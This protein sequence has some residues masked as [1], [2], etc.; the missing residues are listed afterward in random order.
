MTK[1]EYILHLTNLIVNKVKFLS[2]NLNENKIDYELLNAVGVDV[3]YPIFIFN[4]PLNKFF[5]RAFLLAKKQVDFNLILFKNPIVSLKK[6]KKLNKTFIFLENEIGSNL[7][8]T[9]DALNINY[10]VHSNYEKNLN[11]E[12]IKINNSKIDFDYYPFYYFK[13]IIKDGIIIDIKSFILN[14]K[15]FILNLVNTRQKVSNLIL[16]VNIPLPRGYYYFKRN[17][18]NIFIQNLTNK[19]I[20][21]FNYFFKN[22]KINFSSIS[23]IESSTFA[24]INLKVEISLLP[25]QVKHYYFNFGT[26]KYCLFNYKDM[27]D[28]FKISQQKMNEIFDI[29]INSN[30]KQ[31]DCLFNL[32]LP[33]KIWEKWQNFDFD[34]ESENEWLKIK[35]KIIL[36]SDKGEQINSLFKGLKEVSFYRNL[37]W[38]RVFII[39]NNSCYLYAD[40]IKYFNYTLLTKEIFKQNNEI[41]LSFAN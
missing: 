10:I 22:A 21:Y 15:N 3:S 32:S 12:Y 14:G 34:D 23:G 30:D 20:A 26:N 38:K 33:R 7:Y 2:P 25:K 37:G 41:Y 17:V 35:N 24:C 8:Y 5:Y 13:K 18:D 31:L 29:K 9:L 16:E 40:N 39:H 28:F 6:I 4:K 36:K 11:G 1:K 27:E 19:E